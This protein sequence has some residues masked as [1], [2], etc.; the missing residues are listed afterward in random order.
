[1]QAE[2]RQCFPAG[3]MKIPQDEIAFD[4]A[5]KCLRRCGASEK[6]QRQEKEERSLNHFLF[7]LRPCSLQQDVK[8]LDNTR[9]GAG[10]ILSIRA[11]QVLFASTYIQR[12][13]S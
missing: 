2:F 12:S 11:D 3:K 4:R 7:I 10:L 5:L 1:M 13:A 6:D 8:M 9:G